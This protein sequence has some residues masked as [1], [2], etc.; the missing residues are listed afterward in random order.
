MVKE[1][2]GFHTYVVQIPQLLW[3]KLCDEGEDTGRPIAKILMEMIQQRF[4][5]KDGELPKAKRQGRPPKR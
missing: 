5:V 1:K 4:K 2:E 3:D